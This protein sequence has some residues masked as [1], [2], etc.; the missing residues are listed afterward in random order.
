[1]KQVLVLATV[2]LFS[3]T[4]ACAKDLS[5]AWKFEATGAR[6]GTSMTCTLTPATMSTSATS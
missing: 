4:I 2:V 3:P 6:G 1:M 5:G